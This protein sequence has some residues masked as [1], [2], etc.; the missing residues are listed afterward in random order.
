MNI[1]Q[2]VTR[3]KIKCGIYT[4]ALPFENPDQVITEVIQNITRRTFSTFCPYYETYRFNLHDLE[5]LD[6]QAN[7]EVYLL[8]DIFNE[9]ELLFVRDVRYEESDISGLGYWGGGIPLLHGN[10]INQS[11]L[12]NAGLAMT[13]KVIPKMTFKYEH[14]RKITL[15]NVLSSSRVVFDLA[16][17]HDKNLASISPTQEESFYELAVLDVEDMLYQTLKHYDNISSA[18][19]NITLKLDEWS[20]AAS[21]RKTLIDEWE[22]Y[23]HMDIMP[24]MYG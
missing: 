21:E 15:Y 4:I 10:M 9:R 11:I 20:Q 12:S 17:M 6:K 3:I 14:P 22:N 16:L 8:P 5:H 23:Y 2:L 1:S 7:Y 13:N 19:G 24:F 18:Y